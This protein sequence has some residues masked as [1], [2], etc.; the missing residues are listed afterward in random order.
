MSSVAGLLIGMFCT[1]HLDATECIGLTPREMKRLSAR[2]VEGTVR[3]ASEATSH[4]RVVT[5]D[6]QRL[7][8]GPRERT[9]VAYI[10]K[11]V[12]NP[13]PKPGD[14]GV[15]FAVTESAMYGRPEA[16]SDV[17]LLGCSS[18]WPASR[19]VTSQLGRARAIR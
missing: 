4:R 11:I 19:D 10:E 16:P 14:R 13:Y 9:L 5:I 3:D 6:V 2:V 15:F 17:L 7:W 18:V 8:K 12:G 1:G